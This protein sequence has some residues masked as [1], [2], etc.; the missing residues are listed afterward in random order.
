MKWVRCLSILFL[1]LSVGCSNS[2]AAR[3][4]FLKLDGITYISLGQMPSTITE[5]DLTYYRAIE[6]RHWPAIK[7]GD[8]VSLE[9]GTPIFSIAGYRTSFRLAAKGEHGIVI[10]QAEVNPTAAK[11]GDLLDIG[12][13]VVSITVQGSAGDK[14]A[15]IEDRGWIDTMVDMVLGAPLSTTRNNPGTQMVALTLSLADGTFVKKL[16]WLDSGILGPPDMQLPVDFS[17]AVGEAM[18]AQEGPRG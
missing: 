8:S 3:S 14:L 1:L 10:Y 18:Q 4:E 9:V 15:E 2:P 7:D 6:R 5:G 16:F 11:G 12:Q 13:K 17:I